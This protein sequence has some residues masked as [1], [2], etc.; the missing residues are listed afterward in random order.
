MDRDASH[1]SCP[2]PDCDDDDDDRSSSSEYSEKSEKD[3]K[4][5]KDEAMSDTEDIPGSP[6]LM[7]HSDRTALRSAVDP[8][9]RLC[10][11]CR[12]PIATRSRSAVMCTAECSATILHGRC[13]QAYTRCYGQQC[14]ICRQACH[15]ITVVEAPFELADDYC[16]EVGFV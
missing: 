3:E 6:P 12:T 8:G 11:L 4:D 5:E 9:P 2:C 1:Y 14:P 10:P 15:F 16:A 7:S 13:A